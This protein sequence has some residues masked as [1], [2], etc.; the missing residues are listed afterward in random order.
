M[1]LNDKYQKVKLVKCGCA[2][3]LPGSRQISWYCKHIGK[4]YSVED[5]KFNP[6]LY[7]HIIGTPHDSNDGSWLQ[8]KDTEIVWFDNIPQSLFEI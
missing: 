4:I 8:K 2:K 6:E 7:W 3:C 5:Y 1:M